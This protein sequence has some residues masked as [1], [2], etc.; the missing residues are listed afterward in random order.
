MN[1]AESVLVLASKYLRIYFTGMPIVMLYNFSSAFLR[2]MGDSLRPLIFIVVGGI[3]NVILNIVFV[4]GFGL[5]VEGVA[6]ATVV[7]Q[8]VSATLLISVL[9]KSKGEVR[10]EK[11]ICVLSGAN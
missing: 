4:A 2:A 7:S 3:L 6:I 9:I 10:L 8:G 5:T 11:N 1:C